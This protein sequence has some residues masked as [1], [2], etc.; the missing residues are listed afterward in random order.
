MHRLHNPMRVEEWP[1]PRTY[2]S[3][4]PSFASPTSRASRRKATPP[5]RATIGS[6]SVAQ[7]PLCPLSSS[8]AHFAEIADAVLAL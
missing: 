1:S 4:D 5:P 6:P 7:R 2:G 8:N 3:S